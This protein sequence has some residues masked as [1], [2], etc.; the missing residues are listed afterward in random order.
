MI[1]GVAAVARV[2]VPW[3]AVPRMAVTRLAV[4]TGMTV[5]GMT[6][7]RVDLGRGTAL[8]LAVGAGEG[9]QTEGED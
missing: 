6:M 3:V 1:A 2:T 8:S 9:R 4:V 7:R 5:A